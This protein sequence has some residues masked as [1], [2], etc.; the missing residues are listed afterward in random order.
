MEIVWP[1][2]RSVRGDGSVE[3]GSWARQ[4][5]AARVPRTTIQCFRMSH[6]RQARPYRVRVHAMN[7]LSQDFH[8]AFPA[9]SQYTPRRAD[10]KRHNARTH[11]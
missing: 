8:F 5:E 2:L 10:P 9:T 11:F 4:R 6:R 3:D 7:R 1:V